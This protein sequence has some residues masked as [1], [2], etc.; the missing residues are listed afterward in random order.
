VLAYIEGRSGLAFT[1][2]ISRKV[3]AMPTRADFDL[4]ESEF[5]A[6]ER[7][8][9]QKLANMIAVAK[10]MLAKDIQDAGV[11]PTDKGKG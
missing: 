9:R 1:T 3:S 6:A 8:Y 10:A 11:K 7:A 4:A 2:P 5:N